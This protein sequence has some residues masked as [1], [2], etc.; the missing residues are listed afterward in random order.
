MFT[1]LPTTPGTELEGR[2]ASLQNQLVQ[3][4]IDGAL[5]LQN[6]DLFYFSG[7][8]QQAQ[9]YIPA[10]GTPRLL[11]RKSLERAR[12]ESTLACI[13]KLHSPKVLVDHLTAA[14]LEQPKTL[15]LELDVLPAAL[16][17]TYRRIFSKARCVD[18]SAMIRQL[19]A[20]KT[21]F[22]I[23]CIRE[24][25]DLAAKVAGRLPDLVREGMPE[26]ELAGRV[27]AEAR[28]L[29]HQGLVRMRLWNG[30]LFYGH[31]MSGAAAALPSCLASP[32]GGLGLSPAVP[33]GAGYSRIKAFEPIIMDYVFATNGYLADQTRIFALK[34]LPD[35][36]LTA[37]QA[38]LDL[39]DALQARAKPGTKAGDL[40]AFA[41]SWV[42][43]RGYADWFMG[44]DE[45]RIRFIGHGIGLELDEFPFLAAGQDMVLQE[46][47]VIALEPKL[48]FPGKGVVGIEDTHR[49]TPSGLERL[50]SFDQSIQ[51]IK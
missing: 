27:E 22:E 39:Q 1:Q 38:M 28:A 30:E 47:M 17:E 10:Q 37:H 25:A 23:A 42:R 24:A 44:A 16:Y 32:T 18:V 36:L 11:V 13:E 8:T 4:A 41:L 15:G 40:Y 33:Q 19:R 49:V 21:S 26:I 35:E 6:T 3:Q 9:L 45:E 46:N 12:S 50:T 5:I 43:E 2:I 31:L 48:I 7:T 51:I 34:G 20:V 29:G 14:G